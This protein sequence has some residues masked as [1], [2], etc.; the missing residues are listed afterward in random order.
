MRRRGWGRGGGLP[1]D[2]GLEMLCWGVDTS[3]RVSAGGTPGLAAWLGR[4]RP[5]GEVCAETRPSAGGVQLSVGTLS[6]SPVSFSQSF[7]ES[8]SFWHRPLRAAS[9]GSPGAGLSVDDALRALLPAAEPS[10]PRWPRSEP[11]RRAGHCEVCHL[12][13][14]RLLGEVVSLLQARRPGLEARGLPPKVVQF[15]WQSRDVNP[16]LFALAACALFTP[17]SV[18]L[19]L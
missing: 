3:G 18:C 4:D 14:H 10:R 13:R 6:L 17:P 12:T 15:R 11:R 2:L 16:G 7:L 1:W 8:F 5:G 19:F 9:C